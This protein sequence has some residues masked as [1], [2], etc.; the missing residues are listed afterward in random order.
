MRWIDLLD[1]LKKLPEKYLKLQI[2]IGGNNDYYHFDGFDLVGSTIIKKYT[3]L[4]LIEMLSSLKPSILRK[5]IPLGST[6][7][8]VEETLYGDLP[9]ITIGPLRSRCAIDEND[10]YIFP[11]EDYVDQ[12]PDDEI[13]LLMNESYPDM[14]LIKPYEKLVIMTKDGD[15]I[16]D[17]SE[18]IIIN[19]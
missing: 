17:D 11:L 18:S 13:T 6:D 4:E 7:E 14:K 16:V 1:G 12:T 19:K 15:L 9:Y 5:Y 3:G 10:D 8:V 2:I